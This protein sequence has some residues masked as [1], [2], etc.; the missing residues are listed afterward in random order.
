MTRDTRVNLRWEVLVA[1]GAA[2][3][4]TGAGAAYLVLRSGESPNDGGQSGM[5]VSAPPA[6]SRAAPIASS[7]SDSSL[8]DVVVT[9]SQEAVDRAG[10]TVAPIGTGGPT[11]AGQRLP[12]V[13]EPNA[14]RQVTV[15]PLVAGRITRVLVEL[16]E[17][18]RKGQTMA[19][20]FSPELAE[21][22]TR[23]TSVRAELDAHEREL[24]RTQKLVEIGAA[25]RQELERIHAEHTAQTAKVQSA[26]SRLELLGV[27][28]AAL[29]SATPGKL[30]ASINVPAPIAGVVT[31]R[32]ANVGLNVDPAAKLFTVVDLSTVWV[33]ADLYEKDFSRVRVGS[34][35]T[36]TTTAYPDLVLQ[37]RV[38]YI[39]PQVSAQ[40]RTAK[41]R[42][43]VQ[44][45]R[46]ELRLGMYA[47]VTVAATGVATVTAIPRSA[48][49]NVGDHQVV[50]LVN[51]TEPGKFTEREV[52]LGQPS[53]EQ[54]EL[55]SGVRPGDVV[56]TEGSFFVRAER[57][58]LG[59]RTPPAA[60]TPATPPDPGASAQTSDVQTARVTVGD[61]AFEP[62][63]L[64]LRAGVPAR[65][66]FVRTS[67]KTCATE[68]A[69]PALKIKRALPLNQPVVIEFTPAKGELSFA[70]GM[71]MLRGTIVAE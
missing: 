34:P 20:V 25:S 10:I 60:A 61:Q 21:A 30:V 40:T 29:G 66:T 18:V 8:P 6:S 41:L 42:V 67:D 28:P 5:T 17:H 44:N 35:A 24:Q 12:G 59:L 54:V 48:V 13:V 53:G 64:M 1:A 36:V 4:A 55:L 58:R 15:T 39:D 38:S 7:P 3:L 51:P 27:P 33:V 37:G 62:S 46:S 56:V 43:E 71:N 2:L 52:R 31:E 50:Y 26:R 11:A 19:Q 47:D 16:G 32:L 68:V 9:L 69:F 45:A 23:Y 57:E 22:H 14:Y 65:V 49:Q 70:C 63:R